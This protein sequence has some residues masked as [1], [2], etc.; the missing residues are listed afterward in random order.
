[1]SLAFQKDHLA[2]F[3]E[4]LGDCLDPDEPGMKKFSIFAKDHT[5]DV[6]VNVEVGGARLS[7]GKKGSQV[8]ALAANCD[9]NEATVC[10]D[11]VD[12]ALFSENQKKWREYVKAERPRLVGYGH[13]IEWICMRTTKGERR[14]GCNRRR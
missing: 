11:K 4:G 7:D 13:R 3:K 5:D 1:M 14:S 8:F 9:V 12:Q 2:A 6:D 10:A